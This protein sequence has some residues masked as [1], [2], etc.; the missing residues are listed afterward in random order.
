IFATMICEGEPHPMS[1]INVSKAR[2]LCTAAELRLV[3]ASAPKSLAK[4]DE[5]E[6]KKNVERARKLRDKWRD[7]ATRQRR[8]VQQAQAARTTDK[9]ARSQEKTQ[10]FAEVLTRF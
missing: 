9:T 4:L 6:L 2:E 7:Q 10:L 3:E 1:R 8:E 5:A